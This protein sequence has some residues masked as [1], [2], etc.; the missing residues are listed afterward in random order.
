[1]DK[2]WFEQYQN[3]VPHEIDPN[4][5][6]SL[7]SLFH[8]SCTRYGKNTAYSNLGSEITYKEL[9]HFSKNL[10]AYLQQLGL[11][12]GARIGIMMPN[13]MQYPVAIF[14]ILRAGYI[15]VNTNPLYTSDEVEHQM[16]DSGA[17]VLIVLANF[18]KTVEKALPSMPTVKHIIVTQIGDLFPTFKRIAVNFVV[19]H[20]KK[21]V[22]SYTIPHAVTFNYALLEGKQSPL[23]KV[24]LNH[25]DIAFLQYT[26]GTT[27]VA[28]GAIL[29]H[30]NLVA[31]VLQA[32]AWISPLGLS[33]QDIIVTALPLYHIFSLTANCLTFLMLGAKNILITNPRDIGHFIDEIKN[34]RFTAITGVNTLYN[35][36]L[37]HPKFKE[38]DFSTLKL[39]LSGGMALQKSVSLR[40]S[41]I[42]KTRVLEAYGLTETSPAATINPMYLEGYNGSIGLPL[43][44]TDVSIRDD[45]GKE[46]PIGTSGELCIKGPQVMPGYWK[47]PDETALVFTKDGFLKTGDIA[48]MDEQGFL[49]LVDRKK[50]MIV[51]SGFNVYPN[52]VEQVIGMHPGVLEVG[53]VGVI[54]EE[55]GERVKACIVKKDPN[56]TKEQIIAHCREHLTAYKVPKIV[57]FFDELPKT[58]VGKIM[59]RSLKEKEIAAATV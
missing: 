12:K 53:V 41:E 51:V 9:D 47:R 52:E 34:S 40:W 59:R 27:G 56:L 11:E 26:G 14:A 46:V 45:N 54:D 57:E 44:S 36:L 37:N 33:D 8:E 39:A 29:T 24:E 28:K 4:Q 1:V 17:E 13:I 16:N 42:T 55:S 15:V 32:Y 3:N 7:V 35:T 49:Y 6:P 20:I 38:I 58:N 10:A 25:D 2:R 22:P 48:R 31:N 30:G 5:Y 19:K 50:D 18:A 21:M 43:S 23:H